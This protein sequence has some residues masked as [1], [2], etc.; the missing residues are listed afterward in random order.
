MAEPVVD[1]WRRVGGWCLFAV[2]VR[3]TRLSLLASVNSPDVSIMGLRRRWT[4]QYY[5]LQ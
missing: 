4:Q 2:W 5:H 1:S 3:V